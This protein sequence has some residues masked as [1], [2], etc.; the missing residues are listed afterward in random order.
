MKYLYL[1]IGFIALALGVIG[2]VIPLLPTTPF[3]LLATAMFAKGSTRFHTW[4]INTKLYHKHLDDFV[5]DKSM[6]LKTKLMIVIPVTVL[7]M[8]PFFKVDNIYMRVFIITL[9]SVKYY[10]FIFKIKTIKTIKG[11]PYGSN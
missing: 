9:L 2:I 10:Y 4:F 1:S 5:R 3:L 6:T 11:D 8:V 7:L